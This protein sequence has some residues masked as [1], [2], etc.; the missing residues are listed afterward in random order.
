MRKPSIL[1]VALI[2][3]IAL[4]LLSLGLF[5][6]LSQSDPYSWAFPGRED[7]LSRSLYLERRALY[8]WVGVISFLG[9]GVLGLLKVAMRRRRALR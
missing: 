2:G 1:T 9:A 5:L 8:V 6:H 3:A 7:E 4:W